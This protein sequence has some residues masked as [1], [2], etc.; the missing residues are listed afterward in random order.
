M[1]RQYKIDIIKNSKGDV[2]I[3]IAIDGY[4]GSGKSTLARG[5][6]KA[7]GFHV[8]DTGA[9][10]RGFACAFRENNY[11]NVDEQSIDDLLKNINVDIFFDDY[12]QHVVINGKDY[13]SQLREEE[14][15]ILSSKISPYPKLREKTKHIQ[16]DF[17]NKYNCVMEG[18]DI[19]TVVLPNADV[20]FFVTASEE[21]RAKR[22]FDQNKD[23]DVSYEEIL[24]DLRERDFRDE[25]RKIAPLKPAQDSIIIDNSN[26]TLEETVDYCLKCIKN[27]INNKDKT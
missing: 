22:R 3:N 1:K 13:T 18:R 9:I 6:A 26:M 25:H 4:V 2:M 16:R 5:I 7:L 27:K 21:V 17:A 14:I 15:S 24:K 19:G 8:F 12:V 11:K 10:Y 23:G 20:K